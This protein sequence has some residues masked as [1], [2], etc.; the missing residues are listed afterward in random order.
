MSTRVVNT[1]IVL[2]KSDNIRYIDATVRLYLEKKL[3]S[4]C[5]TLVGKEDTRERRWR[6]RCVVRVN[7]AGHREQ[8]FVCGREGMLPMSDFLAYFNGQLR[9]TYLYGG[10]YG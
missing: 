4:G 3:I 10:A 7:L 1:N 5:S 8:N 6:L 2:A 9:T